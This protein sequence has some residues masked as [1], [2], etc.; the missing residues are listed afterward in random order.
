MS[1]YFFSSKIILLKEDAVLDL[2]LYNYIVNPSFNFFNLG[3]KVLFGEDTTIS[4]SM[5]ILEF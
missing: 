3:D 5:P 4:D 2:S 1:Q